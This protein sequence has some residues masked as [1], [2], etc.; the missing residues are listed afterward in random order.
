[1]RVRALYNDGRVAMTYRVTVAFD[2]SGLAIMDDDDARVDLWPPEQLQLI[3]RPQGRTPFR[4]CRADQP[5]RLTFAAPVM[6][7]IAEY[8][9]HLRPR[10]AL[11][12]RSLIQIGG[13]AAGALVMAIMLFVFT[14]PLA[15]QF[16]AA[17]LPE[18]AKTRLG[19]QLAGQLAAMIATR[20]ERRYEDMFCYDETSAAAL[21]Q[22]FGVLA[23]GPARNVRFGLRA[24]DSAQPELFALPGGQIV[25]SGAVPD[26]AGGPAALAGLMA[27]EIGHVA[28]DHPTRMLLLMD[29][30]AVLLSLLPV[31]APP[32]VF[33]A[34]LAHQFVRLGYREAFEEDA[35]V[36][37][38]EALN[39][40]E[41]LAGPYTD[42]RAARVDAGEGSSD[43][44]ARMHPGS[45]DSVAMLREGA[46]GGLR[47]LDAA[48]W[49]DLRKLC[50]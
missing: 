17:V 18:T 13:W 6:A 38:L 15:A 11:D 32:G 22:L 43:P 27:H 30:V 35:E 33:D 9:P 4:V 41:L 44:I 3:D 37:A 47:P 48:Q 14:A 42:F 46:T 50:R 31:N 36:F 5:A 28:D 8:F 26:T 12:R 20:D 7:N 40:V 16:A 19:N 39:G 1:M 29:P 24:I 34:S 23:Q 25:M 21:R 45:E 2:A 49:N 10:G